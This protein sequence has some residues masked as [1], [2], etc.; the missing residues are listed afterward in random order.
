MNNLNL[1]TNLALLNPI[2]LLEWVAHAILG[3]T[4]DVNPEDR[5]TRQGLLLLSILLFVVAVVGVAPEF[6]QLTLSEEMGATFIFAA[7]ALAGINT[8]DNRAGV[9]KKI[10][11]SGDV[12]PHRP[13]ETKG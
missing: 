8:A 5:L 13:D 6:D 9:D 2:K 11:R 12:I 3:G 7:L 4:I 10:A 1:K